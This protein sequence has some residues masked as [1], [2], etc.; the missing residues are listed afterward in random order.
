MPSEIKKLI[1][2]AKK[3]KLSG[4]PTKEVKSIFVPHA[5]YSYS[6]LCAAIPFT[7]ISPTTKHFIILATN[8]KNN[9]I[10]SNKANL[11]NEH[12]YTR[13]VS[14]VQELFP[15]A[16]IES[17]LVG[18]FDITF[19]EKI[20]QKITPDTVI[21]YSSDLTHYGKSYNYTGLP[22]PEQ[23][24]VIKNEEP[25]VKALQDGQYYDDFT[26]VNAGGREVIKTMSYINNK[27]SLHGN[28][29]CY[30][31]SASVDYNNFLNSLVIQPS[32]EHFVSY[33]SMIF[34]PNKIVTVNRFDELQLLAS[35]KS[36]VEF[37]VNKLKFKFKDLIVPSW[38]I[39]QIKNQGTFVGLSN[40]TTKDI[41]ASRGHYESDNTNTAYNVVSSAY[42][43]YNDAIERWGGAITV[44]ELPQITYQINLLDPKKQWKTY[45]YN[46]FI[47][48]MPMIRC[49]DGIYITTKSGNAATYLPSVW[50]KR[51][52][53][54]IKKLL[55][56]LL[57][58][59]R[60]STLENSTIL[61]YKTRLLT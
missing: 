37:R 40:S 58:K 19:A 25:L 52:N 17:Y 8:H 9:K 1:T 2:L 30:H 20:M 55:E 4:K 23:L 6:G 33:L 27:L 15:N 12:S 45:S 32:S 16:I 29:T 41:R 48:N 14:F 11:V 34:T 35:A 26:K 53:W 36:V 10:T 61:L 60:G 49:E 3:L 42:S 54:T 21:V 39:W 50:C 47:T 46:E 28:V 59:S 13:V 51:P 43:C 7:Y 24:F 56:S 22:K 18:K 38:S 31:T 44:E 57:E 5:G